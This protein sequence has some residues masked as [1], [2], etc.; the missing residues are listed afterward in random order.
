MNHSPWTTKEPSDWDREYELGLQLYGVGEYLGA[1]ARFD[2]CNQLR[3]ND[4]QTLHLR[5]ATYRKLQKFEECLADNLKA[6]RIDPQHPIHCNN[7]GDA[8]LCLGRRAEA[9]KWLDKALKRDPK[10]V[11]ALRNK[12]TWLRQCYRFEEAITIYRKLKSL[13]PANAKH[14]RDL[15]YVQLL[16]GQF[17]EGWQHRDARF[18][19]PGLSI[20]YPTFPRPIWDG[21]EGI[22]DKTILIYADE[23]LGD[24]IQF[25]R[26]VP[27]VA[28]K[29]ARVLLAVDDALYPILAPMLGVDQ[30]TTISTGGS[31]AFD[32]YSPLGSLPLA[33]KTT[34]STI[35]APA[36]LSPISPERR[37]KW[38]NRLGGHDRLRVGLVWSG[39]PNHI[40]D[41]NRSVSLQ[42]LSPLFELDATFVSLQKDLRPVDRTFLVTRPD[43]LDFAAE[44]TDFSETAALIER[45][46]LVITVDTSVAHL[47]ATLGRPTWILLP[48]LC[49][50]RWL[51][52]RSDSPWYPTVRLFRQTE[53]RNYDEVIGRVSDELRS[54]ISDYASMLAPK[55]SKEYLY[56]EALHHVKAGAY[57]EA[58]QLYENLLQHDPNNAS[59]LHL[60]GVLHHCCGRYE[61]AVESFAAA[62]RKDPHPNYLVSLG[63]TLLKLERCDEAIRCF[64]KA[65]QLKA[66]DA[67]VWL[68][69]G[70]ALLQLQRNDL[71]T[72]A[73]R[74]VLDLDPSLLDASHK[75]IVPAADRQSDPAFDTISTL[76]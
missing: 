33:F 16:S 49:D 20:R 50:W 69:F 36:L 3:P 56:Q 2:A 38:E 45:L 47:S 37:E 25:A 64:E 32:L 51:T 1:L 26:Y 65:V 76:P 19:V 17:E 61:Q 9:A 63:N 24:T 6:H 55:N 74:H 53:S 42:A 15:G 68:N 11:E 10:N 54:F 73:F 4:A 21:N 58:Q 41:H 12:A 52:D 27:M 70:N 28:A 48:Y 30:C 66:D 40:D 75:A 67:D 72:L 62:I 59:T 7:V 39:N 43:V 14:Q 71:A 8:L 5:A 57:K 29:G 34:L 44:F 23:G 18:K 13:E 35:P 22:T 46:D 31:F 60:M